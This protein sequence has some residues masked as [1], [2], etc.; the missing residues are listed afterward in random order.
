MAEVLHMFSTAS[1]H[2]GM[3]NNAAIESK[4]WTDL[5]LQMVQTHCRPSASGL[6]LIEFRQTIGVQRIIWRWKD[7][8]WDGFFR[9]P[10]IIILSCFSFSGWI[11]KDHQ[12]W[13]WGDVNIFAQMSSL[14]TVKFS[15]IMVLWW[16]LSIQSMGSHDSS[17]IF[18][19]PV[20]LIHPGSYDGNKKCPGM[21]GTVSGCL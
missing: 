15:L 5:V 12:V 10:E 13:I 18:R 20:P 17:R 19:Y 14:G 6:L 9:V 8:H 4:H 21:A 11:N 16:F 7:N 2:L 3:S 1:L